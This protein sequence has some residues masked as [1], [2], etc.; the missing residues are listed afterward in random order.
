MLKVFVDEEMLHMI[1]IGQL[2]TYLSIHNFHPSKLLAIPCVNRTVGFHI[3]M[4][5][6]ANPLF[7]ITIMRQSFNI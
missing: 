7:G 4:T 2:L 5:K 1:F 3:Y 6:G